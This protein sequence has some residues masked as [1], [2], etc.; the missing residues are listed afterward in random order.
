MSRDTRTHPVPRETLVRT[1]GCAGQ[2]PDRVMTTRDFFR[3]VFANTA[4]P[5]LKARTRHAG[6]GSTESPEAT[7]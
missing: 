2:I 1:C 4:A 7:R 5:P 6:A 3:A